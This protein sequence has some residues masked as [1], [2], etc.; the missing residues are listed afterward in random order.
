MRKLHDWPNEPYIIEFSLDGDHDSVEIFIHNV[1]GSNWAYADYIVL[2]FK[3]I[4][5]ITVTGV[6]F[7]ETALT[8]D[9]DETFSLVATV[10][11][12]NAANTN[13]SWAS[14]VESVAK[15]SETGIVT[16][17]APGEATITVTTED[18]GFTA[19]AVITVVDR[20]TSVETILLN[21]LNIYP[22]PVTDG[23]IFISTSKFTGEQNLNIQLISLDGRVVMDNNF[24][25]IEGQI[26]SIR[27][28]INIENGLY[29]LRV[30]GSDYVITSRVMIKN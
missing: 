4:A 19:S 23:Q 20:K 15:V 17:L 13:V 16:A 26:V 7:N 10:A 25:V 12:A 5:E 29:L 11:P 21:S 14:N 6:A 30:S 18:G 8:L 27:L 3:E 1:T 9:I 2:Y 24:S 22:N 28:N